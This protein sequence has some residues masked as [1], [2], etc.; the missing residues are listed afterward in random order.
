MKCENYSPAGESICI[1][2][3]VAMDGI[4][5]LIIQ[6]GEPGQAAPPD[7]A[8]GSSGNEERSAPRVET[9]RAICF[10]DPALRGRFFQAA[11]DLV[12]LYFV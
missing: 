9:V 5:K 3:P 11:E 1:N 6:C 8:E 7:G 10:C 12:E 4:Y 2:H